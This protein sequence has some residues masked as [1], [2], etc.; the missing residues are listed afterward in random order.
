MDP[1]ECVRRR[2]LQGDDAAISVGVR[3]KTARLALP[4]Q[5]QLRWALFKR[6]EAPRPLT[7]ARA[8]RLALS[9]NLSA[10]LSR[11]SLEAR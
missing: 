10:N 4:R 1:V 11:A 6:G 8:A 2:T 9:V 3:C 5:P 7:L